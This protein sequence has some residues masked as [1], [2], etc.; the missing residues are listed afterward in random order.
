MDENTLSFIRHK[1]TNALMRAHGYNRR[2]PEHKVEFNPEQ[3]ESQYSMMYA[4]AEIAVQTFLD[5]LMD[6]TDGEEIT[7][8]TATSPSP[9]LGV[10]QPEKKEGSDFEYFEFKET[11]KRS[12]VEISSALFIFMQTPPGEPTYVSDVR[13]W[14]DAI[15]DAGISDD[16]EVEGFLHTSVDKKHPVASKIE[17]GDCGK[18]DTV[19][20]EHICPAWEPIEDPK[21]F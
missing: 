16:T 5:T 12:A 3:P 10:V 8:E 4:D 1:V 9:L 20:A 6:L 11:P 2:N 21:L 19:L 18:M 15:E 7:E 13:D 17:C 14:L